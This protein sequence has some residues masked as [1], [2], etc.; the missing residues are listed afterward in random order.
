MEQS[1]SVNKKHLDVRVAREQYLEYLEKVQKDIHD[2]KMQR[3]LK[4]TMVDG[5]DKD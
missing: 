3:F 5:Q 4:Q 1:G 2:E